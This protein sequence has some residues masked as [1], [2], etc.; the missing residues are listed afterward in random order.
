MGDKDPHSKQREQKQKAA[1]KRDDA[2]VAKTKQDSN[3]RAPQPVA[4]PKR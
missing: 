1:A 2:A 3:A 4:K